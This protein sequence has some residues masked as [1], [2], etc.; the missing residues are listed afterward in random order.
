M[1]IVETENM[2]RNFQLTDKGTLLT[3]N[4]VFTQP[5]SGEIQGFVIAC[6]KG[7]RSRAACLSALANRDEVPVMGGWLTPL[8]APDAVFLLNYV[9]V[10]V[11]ANGWN[12]QKTVFPAPCVVEVWTVLLLDGELVLQ[13][14][15]NAVSRPM[16]LVCRVQ[17]K[18]F[19]PEQRTGFLRRTVIPAVRGVEIELRIADETGQYQDGAVYYS[20]RSDSTGQRYPIAKEALGTPLRFISGPNYTYN[21]GDFIIRAGEDYQALYR[22]GGVE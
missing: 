3:L 5:K 7:G 15:G 10:G 2:A 19:A 4:W 17:Q 21:T 12:V 14:K 13:C 8:D 16:N 1:R 20:L 18:E 6:E 22:V 9:P 11:T